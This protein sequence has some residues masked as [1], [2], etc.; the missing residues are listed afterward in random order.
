MPEMPEM[1]KKTTWYK[2][3]GKQVLVQRKVKSPGSEWTA[4][5]PNVDTIVKTKGVSKAVSKPAKRRVLKGAAPMRTWYKTLRNGTVD[6]IRAQEK[7]A[8]YS[9]HKPA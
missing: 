8:G 7:P 1:T 6:R 5:K 9:S 2:L 3:S 4:V